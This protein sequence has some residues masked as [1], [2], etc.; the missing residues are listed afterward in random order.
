MIS[1]LLMI[2]VFAQKCTR[3]I[4]LLFQRASFLKMAAEGEKVEKEKVLPKDAQVGLTSHPWNTSYILI[5]WSICCAG[6]GGHLEGHG[7]Q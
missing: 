4:G 2:K 5:Q 1:G 3:L 7:H 6:D